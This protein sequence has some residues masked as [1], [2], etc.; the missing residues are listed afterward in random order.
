MS[1]SSNLSQRATTYKKP[2]NNNN[3]KLFNYKQ[4]SIYSRGSI[5][6]EFFS[7]GRLPAVNTTVTTYKLY[8]FISYEFYLFN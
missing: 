6:E 7:S 8:I 2:Y 4:Q 1:F 5:L 3:N